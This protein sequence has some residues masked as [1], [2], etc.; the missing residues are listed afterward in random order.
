MVGTLGIGISWKRS[1]IRVEPPGGR[2]GERRN[3]KMVA[4]RLVETKSEGV[5]WESGFVDQEGYEINSRRCKIDAGQGQ[6]EFVVVYE[7]VREVSP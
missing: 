6:K 4:C 1:K 7:D 3:P 5:A 2:F